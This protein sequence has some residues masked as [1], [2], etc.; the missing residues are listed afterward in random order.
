T[1]AKGKAANFKN[2]II[3]LTSN[4]GSEFF[5][6]S[7]AL[8]GFAASES[9]EKRKEDQI[10]DVQE[11]IRETLKDYFRPEFLNRLDEVIIFNQLT[12]K[13]ITRIVDIQLKKM[14]T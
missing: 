12:E 7:G 8:L 11:R 3:I 2:T 9:E 10:K 1:D 4:I 13:D 14:V 5:N 6:Q